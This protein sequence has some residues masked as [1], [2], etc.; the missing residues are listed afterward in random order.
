MT[1]TRR[2]VLLLVLTVAVVVGA[3]LPA[4]ALFSDTAA[5]VTRPSI[6]TAVV[7]G[8]SN[9][10]VDTSCVTTTTVIRR[11]YTMYSDVLLNS[12]TTTTSAVSTSNVESN[13]TVRTDGSPAAGQY[14]VTQTIADTTLYATATWKASQTPG[15]TGYQMTAFLSNGTAYAMGNAA[16]NAT[17]FTGTYDAS[18]VNYRPV[19]SMVTLTS[20]GWTAPGTMS[21]VVTC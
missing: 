4:N 17:K 20:Y 19:L 2:C 15:I 3:S 13:T 16:T 8:P 14:T 1:R 9:V 7:T 12:S 11:V 10:K 5:P 18:V 6:T 21:N